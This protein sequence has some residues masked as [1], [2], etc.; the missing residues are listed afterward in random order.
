V[1]QLEP[2]PESPRAAVRRQYLANG[3][4]TG[5]RRFN[6]RDVDRWLA[7]PPHDDPLYSPYNPLPM[8]GS[9]REAWY[10]DLVRR[11]AQVP[12]AVDHLDGTMIGRIFLRFVN[13]E[14]G[15]A[16][17]GIDLDPRYVGQGYGTDA[18]RAFMRYYFGPLNFRRLVLSVASYN[19]RARRS[20]ERCGFRYVGRHWER[21]KSEADV[22]GDQRYRQ[23]R[24]L[25]RRT[26]TGLEALFHT[27]LANRRS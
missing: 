16:V 10:D 13:R 17:L 12:F 26:R 3:A 15:A 4:R 27:M 6:R 22:F 18:L 5:I 25:F 2:R 24:P 11:Q 21:L 1:V 8:S 7:W 23:L 19:V 9:L 14:Q 20:Y